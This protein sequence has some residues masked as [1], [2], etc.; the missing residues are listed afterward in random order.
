M[1]CHILCLSLLPLKMTKAVSPLKAGDNQKWEG[2]TGPKIVGQCSSEM[3]L[4]MT[5]KIVF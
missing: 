1:N 2:W 5:F 4:K 3:Q